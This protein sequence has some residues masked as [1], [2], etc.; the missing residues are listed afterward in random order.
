MI[1]IHLLRLD[2]QWSRG[3]HVGSISGFW[4]QSLLS[5][6]VEAL[7]SA[8]KLEE[9]MS[10]SLP[11]GHNHSLICQDFKNTHGPWQICNSD[12]KMQAAH[13]MNR[14]IWSRQSVPRQSRLRIFHEGCDFPAACR[15][16]VVLRPMAVPRVKKLKAAFSLDRRCW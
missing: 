12:R 14:S 2:Q 8:R 5:S 15:E 3:F 1:C 7:L 13:S 10:N 9:S 16:E 6:G 11:H 4:A